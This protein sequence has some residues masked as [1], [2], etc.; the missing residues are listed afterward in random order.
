MQNSN[1]FQLNNTNNLLAFNMGYGFVKYVYDNKANCFESCISKYTDENF[2]K[3][4]L[5][6]G[7]RYVVGENGKH[8]LT[9]DK[10]DSKFQRILTEYTLSKI[11]NN[12]LNVISTMP[13]NSYLVKSARENFKNF[14]LSFDKIKNVIIYPES[15]SLSILYPQFFTNK[16]AYVLDFGYYT[17]NV[18]MF[19]NGYLLKDHSFSIDL[20]YSILESRI[21]TKLEQTELCIMNDRQIKYMFDNPTVDNIVDD[22]IEEI[23]L[24]ISKKQIPTNIDCFVT[25]GGSIKI[26]NKL[27]Q[28]FSA[29]I[30]EN[31]IYDNVLGL[32]KI[33]GKYFEQNF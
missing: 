22:Y 1:N 25:G 14:L 11:D 9:L 5:H 4:I 19:D 15:A 12:N 27:I 3:T 18:S 32:W 26:S 7:I 13:M 30:S 8:N 33:G 10:S 2:N 24:E 29:K 6:E 20:G 31:P 17:I 23:K 16:L 21:K 28:N